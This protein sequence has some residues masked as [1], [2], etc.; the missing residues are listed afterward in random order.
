MA[1]LLEDI[2]FEAI[3]NQEFE[4]LENLS[5]WDFEKVYSFLEHEGMLVFKEWNHRA[6]SHYLD[7]VKSAIQDDCKWMEF[8]G[9]VLIKNSCTHL[10]NDFVIPKGLR[11]RAETTI[12]LIKEARKNKISYL[13]VRTQWDKTGSY[14]FAKSDDRRD[15]WTKFSVFCEE[16][17][18]R[19]QRRYGLCDAIRRAAPDTNMCGNWGVQAQVKDEAFFNGKFHLKGTK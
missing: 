12:R 15:D 18:D 10:P 11:F 3:L 2:D 17:S 6:I 13:A 5:A 7:M 4:S 1:D 19:L 9:A 8:S 16:R 14:K